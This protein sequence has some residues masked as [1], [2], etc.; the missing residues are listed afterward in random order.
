[1]EHRKQD[2]RMSGWRDFEYCAMFNTG[3][4]DSQLFC[5]VRDWCFESWGPSCELDYWH[6]RAKPNGSWCWA[7]DEFKM[8]IY[9]KTDVEYALFLLRWV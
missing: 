1:M 4:A 8:K 5:D 3:K 2:K 7:N 9:F 6:A